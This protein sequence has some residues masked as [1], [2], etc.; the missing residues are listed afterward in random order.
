VHL[1]INGGSVVEGKGT[2]GGGGFKLLLIGEKWGR[3]TYALGSLSLT[4]LMV[5]EL[6]S[7]FGL[8][9]A[10][11]ENFPWFAVVARGKDM[12]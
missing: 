11:G 5:F 7:S 2:G 12:V 8:D 6:G 1:G 4:D 3:I 9:S 10:F